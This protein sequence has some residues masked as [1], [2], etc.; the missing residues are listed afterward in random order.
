MGLRG[1][2]RDEIIII[3]IKIEFTRETKRLKQRNE[4]ER[5]LVAKYI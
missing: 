3:I 1:T 5:K 4:F 2:K